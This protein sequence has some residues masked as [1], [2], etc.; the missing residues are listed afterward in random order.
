MGLHRRQ[1]GRQLPLRHLKPFVGYWGSIDYIG[2]DRVLGTR[3][4]RYPDGERSR[5]GVRLMI[6]QLNRAK[7]VAKGDLA[8][9]PVGEFDRE[10]NDYWFLGK[11]TAASVFHRLRLH[12]RL[13]HRGD[14]PLR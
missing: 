4:F 5:G 7:T 14:L 10:N 9:T 13:L 3:T 1:T 6:G 8:M 11:E 12:R 2:N